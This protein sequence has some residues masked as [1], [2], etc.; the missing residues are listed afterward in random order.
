MH[1]LDGK[2]LKPL[3]ITEAKETEWRKPEEA[4]GTRSTSP[5]SPWFFIG[6]E[7]S[8]KDPFYSPS[9]GQ[10]GG[11]VNPFNQLPKCLNAKGKILSKSDWCQSCIQTPVSKRDK[12]PM[13][14]SVSLVHREFE[15]SDFEEIVRRLHMEDKDK[16]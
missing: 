1:Y 4:E 15:N 12:G 7:M 6:N 8:K 13:R 3:N 9:S 2:P 10:Q 14:K 16:M 11:F 5:K